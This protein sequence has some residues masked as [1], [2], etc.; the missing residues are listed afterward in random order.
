MTTTLDLYSKLLRFHVFTFS[1]IEAIIG[2]KKKASNAV[3]NLK[4][5]GLIVSV[6]K[7]L[8]SAV[9][10]SDKSPVADK[11]EIASKITP[12]SFVSHH[13]AFE[14]YGIANQVFYEMHVSSDSKF[15][16][17][18]FD[19]QVYKYIQNKYDFGITEIKHVK[20]TDMERTVLDSIKD[21][22]KKSGLEEVLQCINL[23]KFLDEK[24]LIAYLAKYDNNFLYQKTGFILNHFSE[25]H[26]SDGFFEHCKNAADT[27]VRYLCRKEE[28]KSFVF[29]KEWNL[30]I[31][32]ELTKTLNQGDFADV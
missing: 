14:F 32:S 1:D 10:L 29:D 8:Y 3:Y 16:N 27:S 2:D 13:S 30:C 21:F 31:P 4:K 25:L 28:A 6:K 22:E 26:L 17:F 18:S 5:N 20:V 12:T 19:G 9:S 11:F 15:N 24:K 7:N 23:V